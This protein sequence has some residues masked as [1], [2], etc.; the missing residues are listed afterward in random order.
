MLF[1]SFIESI[2]QKVTLTDEEKLLIQGYLI[3]KKIRKKTI[4]AATGR[5][6][7]TFYF[8]H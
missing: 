3:P 5:N 8:R 7:P 4:S 6:L 2:H 1:D